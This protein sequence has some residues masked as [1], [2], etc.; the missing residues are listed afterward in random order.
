[1][2]LGLIL[3]GLVGGLIQVGLIGLLLIVPAGLVPGGTW[4]WDRALVFLAVYGVT[5]MSNI[6]A[7]GVLAPASLA[8]RMRAPV[9]ER[10]PAAD[11]L[12]TALIFLTFLGWIA[13]IPLDVFVWQLLPPP[14]PLV[15][16]LG[17]LVLLAGYAVAVGAIYQNAFAAPIVEDQ[18]DR[19]QTLVDSGLYGVVRHPHYLG[20]LVFFAGLAVWLGSS[21]G[22]L[23]VSVL[24][25]VLVARIAV[26]EAELRAKLP[27]YGEYVARVRYRLVPLVW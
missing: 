22:L 14:S 23:A 3:K 9:S 5:V 16:G 1:M 19:G 27:G 4:V 26:E 15:A 25:A 13:C 12:V 18:T 20:M 17:G 2:S 21:A 7:L 11:R 10:Q 6:V 8:A 24:A